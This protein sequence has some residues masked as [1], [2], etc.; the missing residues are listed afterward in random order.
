METQAQTHEGTKARREGRGFLSLRFSS[1]PHP[2]SPSV[3]PCLRASVPS[4]DPSSPSVPP[5]V[6][7]FVP[8]RAFTL[9]EMVVVIGIIILLVAMAIPAIRGLTGSRSIDAG[10]NTLSALI[11]RARE[12]AVGLQEV[13][14]VLFWLDPATDRINA[15][16][17]QSVP[18]DSSD[19]SPLTATPATYY[20]DIVPDREFLQLP[21]GIGL[22]VINNGG[23]VPPAWAAGQTYAQNAL[24]QVGGSFYSCKLTNVSSTANE[25]PNAT[26]WNTAQILPDRYIGFN[27]LPSPGAADTITSAGGNAAV[28]IGGAILFDGNGRLTSKTYG[29]KLHQSN[30]TSPS[31]LAQYIFGIPSNA[32]MPT[33]QV[34]YTPPA[35]LS[36]QFGFVLFDREA[37][38]NFGGTI[39]DDLLDPTGVPNGYGVASTPAASP[40]TEADEEV[41]LDTNSAPILINR[42]NGTLIRAE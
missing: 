8:S 18:L 7:A 35:A 30:S 5:C 22:Q 36:S 6:R 20:L 24:V 31:N 39:G 1:R 3:P 28:R 25:P 15:S 23:V 34:D 40:P 11:T 27:P 41:W 16:I 42:Y 13:H 38:N 2:S 32:V 4:P 29:L 19:E 12:E 33:P 37:F 21:S 10:Y 26:Y 17:V 9:T 14:G